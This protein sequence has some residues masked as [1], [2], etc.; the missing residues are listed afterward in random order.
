[1][2]VVV[3]EEKNQ[4]VEQVCCDVRWRAGKT[5]KL[6]E[7]L[8]DIKIVE[9][10]TWYSDLCTGPLRDLPRF[11]FR[12]FPAYLWT[13]PAY[14]WAFPAYTKVIM[15]LDN[16]HELYRKYTII[17]IVSNPVPETFKAFTPKLAL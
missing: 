5:G 16:N 12:T 15:L 2:I 10:R 8:Y 11:V 3:F 6:I 14:P 7:G 17:S 4:L 13:F 1:M 9:I